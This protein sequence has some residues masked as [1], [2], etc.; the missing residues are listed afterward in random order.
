MY[1]LNKDEHALAIIVDLAEA[2]QMALAILAHIQ[3]WETVTALREYGLIPAVQETRPQ[4][5]RLAMA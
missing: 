3:V 2:R 5:L 4:Q 1:P